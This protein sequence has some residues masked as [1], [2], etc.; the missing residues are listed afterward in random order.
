MSRAN[1]PHLSEDDIGPLYDDLAPWAANLCETAYQESL[2]HGRRRRAARM[3]FVPGWKEAAK[4]LGRPDAFRGAMPQGVARVAHGLTADDLM[5]LARRLL[6]Q[7]YAD[8]E[9]P[10]CSREDFEDGFI[11]ALLALNSRSS[12]KPGAWPADAT[13]PGGR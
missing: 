6:E 13:P 11:A 1:P 10:K 7:A 4:Q 5:P 2:I 3:D 9:R 12:F 8:R